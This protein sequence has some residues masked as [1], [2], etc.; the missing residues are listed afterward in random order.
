MSIEPGNGWHNERALATGLVPVLTLARDALGCQTVGEALSSPQFQEV[1]DV[2][3]TLDEL[4]AVRLDSLPPTTGLSES[5]AGRI[6]QIIEE[7]DPWS[8]EV[9]VRNAVHETASLTELG[10]ERDMSRERVRK[11]KLKFGEVL[12]AKCGPHAT[13]IAAMVH[14]ELPL[15]ARRSVLDRRLNAAISPIAATRGHDDP[16]TTLAKHL[17]STRLTLPSRGDFVLTDKGEALVDKLDTVIQAKA[18]EL[19][20]VD[21]DAIFKRQLDELVPLRSEV[22]EVLNLTPMGKFVGLRDTK[23][24]RAKAA[25]VE[26]GRVATKDEIGEIAGIPPDRLSGA[27][28]VID[29]VVRADKDS[30]G[31]VEWVDDVYRGIP[32]SIEQ[33]INEHGGAVSLEFLRDDIASRYAV[34]PES[35]NAY[36]AT[37][38]FET[39]AGM[40]RMASAD[41][42]KYRPL[43]EVAKRDADGNLYWDFKVEERYRRGY[44]IVRFPGELAHYL[45]C[46]PNSNHRVRVSDSPTETVMVSW[47]LSSIQRG[48]EIGRVRE[49]LIRLGAVGGERG[50]LTMLPDRSV[51]FELLSP[52]PVV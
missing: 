31:L 11:L 8:V 39:V 18:D 33:R 9:F 3:G 7:S 29:S 43:Y 2:A 30:W 5:F 21:L 4:G 1:L 52:P 36:V 50:R 40:V 6:S 20:I 37:P 15:I 46:D 38:Q 23:R 45:G 27:L 34:K 44:S 49:T 35:V 17:V 10:E 48:A 28:S 26:I 13:L 25:L 12:E 16:V 42:Y 24:A 51:R 19:G 47:R 32:A 22:V 41:S 14:S